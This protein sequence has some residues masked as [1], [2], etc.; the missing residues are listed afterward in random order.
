MEVPGAGAA[1]IF[2][3]KFHGATHT[4]TQRQRGPTTALADFLI[5]EPHPPHRCT[6][7]FSV[8]RPDPLRIAFFLSLL[9]V[10]LPRVKTHAVLFFSRI[11]R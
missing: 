11:F 3:P 4:D 8:S 5:F 1:N 2:S 7:K 6:A 10:F 9:F